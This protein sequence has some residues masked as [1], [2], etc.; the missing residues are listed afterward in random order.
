MSMFEKMKSLIPYK[1]CQKFRH[2]SEFVI[3][4]NYAN[5]ITY[6]NS[7][8]GDIFMLCDGKSTINDICNHMLSEYQVSPEII[9]NDIVKIIR[10]LQWNKLIK[11]SKEK[12]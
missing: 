8:A 12:Q 10:D 7:T 11:L 1:S 5:K 6:L 3:I 9:Q 2:D 4:S